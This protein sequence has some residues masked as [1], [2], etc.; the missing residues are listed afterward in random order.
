MNDAH[1]LAS[2]VMQLLAGS[3]K[4]AEVV[5]VEPDAVI[6]RPA[7]EQESFR[8]ELAVIG[9]EAARGDVVLVCGGEDG[10]FVIGVLGS[11][12][13]RVAAPASELELTASERI[14]LR[15]PVLE[16]EASRVVERA[17]DTYRYASG[18]SHVAAG[19]QRTVVEGACEVV[20]GRTSIVSE[21]DTTIDGARVL[22]G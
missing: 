22:L 4:R 7:Q 5:D 18:A 3:A 16:I 8:A 2:P 13:R 1:S 20:A 17:E 19:T 6:V 11:A 15:A 21:E 14:V 9:Y 10:L 12:R